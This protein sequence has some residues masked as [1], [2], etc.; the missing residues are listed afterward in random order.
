MLDTDEGIT[1]GSTDSIVLG[2][3]VGNVDV[4]TLGIDFVT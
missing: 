2:N 3:I 4:I 1:L